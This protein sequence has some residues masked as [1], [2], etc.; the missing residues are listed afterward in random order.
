MVSYKS[1]SAAKAKLFRAE[2]ATC[3]RQSRPVLIFS[4]SLDGSWDTEL[5]LGVHLNNFS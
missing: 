3:L 5:F 1:V 4:N 2:S